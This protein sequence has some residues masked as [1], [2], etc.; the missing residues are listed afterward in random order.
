MKSRRSPALLGLMFLLSLAATGAAPKDK[1]RE[2]TL[3]L[4]EQRR[5][6]FAVPEGY[7]L[8]SNKDEHGLITARLTDPKEKIS[9]Q[10]TFFP[11][12]EGT[13]STARGRKE[14]MVESFQ[15]FVSGSVEQSMRFEELSPK[16]GAGTYCVFTDSALIGKD[17]YPP[18]EYLN[19]TTGVKSWPG[20]FAVFTLLSNDTKSSEYLAALKVLRESLAE[21]P[22]TPLL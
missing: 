18:G 6:S 12:R 19:S 2:E 15:Q 10:V 21:Q 13:C 9:L 3:I 7:S 16:F 1:G 4:F 17:K 8:A 14:F 22:L 20:C 11:D 5:V